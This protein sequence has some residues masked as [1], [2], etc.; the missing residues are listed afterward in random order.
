VRVLRLSL[1]YSIVITC[2]VVMTL[3]VRDHVPRIPEGLSDSL[4]AF[5]KECFHKAPAQRPSA[6]KLSQH[7][8]LN[9][10]LSKVRGSEPSTTHNLE[11]CWMN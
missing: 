5:L 2:S 1:K 9:W 6:K 7:E 8:W 10:S 11:V 4:G 3:I